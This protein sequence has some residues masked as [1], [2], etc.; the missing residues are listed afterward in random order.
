MN[1]TSLSILR[2]V[3]LGWVAF[4]ALGTWSGGWAG[5][6]TDVRA[7]AREYFEKGYRYHTGE[8]GAPDLKR[9]LSYYNKALRLDPQLFAALYN[10]GLAYYARKD[11]RRARI[12]FTKAAVAARREGER[13]KEYESM[14]RNGL[15]SALQKQKKYKAAEQQFR[16]A[17]H[18]YPAL[19]EAHY[20]LINLLIEQERWE[21]AK[22][23]MQ[24]AEKAAPSSRYEIFTGRLRGR[25]GREGSKA[26]G[27]GVGIAAVV[28][29]I[30]LYSLYLR[31]RRRN[32]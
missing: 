18:L 10:A 23:A 29:M 27:G 6:D 5:A 9:A 4:F 2:V 22:R 20:N 17:I 26:V 31:A 13:A 7:K 11:Y 28:G 14:A 3:V 16:A 1:R 15:G 25:E 19:V 12:L 32:R 8:E 24:A 30:L 21:E